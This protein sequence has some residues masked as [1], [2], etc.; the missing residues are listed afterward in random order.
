MND[1][2]DFLQFLEN[3]SII[4][5]TFIRQEYEKMN[6]Q[7]ILDQTKIWKATDGRWKAYVDV[8]G[9]RRLI[10]KSNRAALEDEIIENYKDPKIKF[11]ECFDSWASEKLEYGEIQKSTYDRYQADY[12]RYIKDTELEYKEVKKIDELFL[13]NFIKSTIASQHLT[14]KGWGNLRTLIN[15]SM[16]YAHKHSY[17][18][19]RVSLFMAE[20]Q[21]SRKA[22]EQR[23]VNDE[24]QVFTRDEE[25]RI[26]KYIADN[27][28]MLS[29]GVA[30]TF[31]TGLRVGEV[32]ALKWSDY[33]GDFLS[34]TRTEIKYIGEHGERIADVRERTKG[35]DG[36]RQVVLN[37]MAIGIL[38]KLKAYMGDSEWMFTRDGQRIKA[39]WLS[40]RITKLCKEL[41]MPHRSF[42]KIR[43]TYATKLI[44][45]GV[46]EKVVTKQMGHTEI[47]T[48]KQFYYFNNEQVAEIKERLNKV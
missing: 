43:K 6:R 36:R 48:T 7:K 16:V 18:E 24:E 12:K 42:H 37:D 40:L 39:V 32:A 44:D 34:V 8:A 28:D 19:F 13:E 46:P 17:T 2:K 33:K 27:P 25:T 23:V 10:A 9:K 5:F 47:L 4:D 3:S 41:G 38:E 45:A 35:R 15:G 14:A 1:E 20:L 29:L 30:L 22:F 26:E 21:L 31:C 11:K